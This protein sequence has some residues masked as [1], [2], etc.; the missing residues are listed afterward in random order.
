MS[1]EL[2]D[3]LPFYVI[4]HA[5]IENF[6]EKTG[7]IELSGHAQY[8]IRCIT[9]YSKD[10]RDSEWVL[11]RDSYEK[12]TD[13][14]VSSNIIEKWSNGPSFWILNK[15][16]PLNF[17]PVRTS[18]DVTDTRFQSRCTSK[19]FKSIR[20]VSAIKDSCLFFV[21]TNCLHLVRRHCHN[22]IRQHF[23]MFTR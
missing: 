13:Q 19:Y 16:W 21:P 4:G 23:G 10:S 6:F 2:F 7:K 1:V 5:N 12:I 9:C 17:E 15:F 22:D 18:V 14:S 20:N 8:S 11:V 3:F